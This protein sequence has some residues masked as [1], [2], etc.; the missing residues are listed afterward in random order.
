M[1]LCLRGSPLGLLKSILNSPCLLI[2]L[3]HTEHKT[4]R[5]NLGLTA[6]LYY[7]EGELVHWVDKGK[8][9][10]WLTVVQLPIKARWWGAPVV[11]WYF[12][13]T[14]KH[15]THVTDTLRQNP[16]N[17]ISYFLSFWGTTR[18]FFSAIFWH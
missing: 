8:K 1:R 16:T 18:N 4:I 6:R 12:S 2:L 3:I 11:L 17:S 10:V 9:K 5:W 15:C 7:L 14:N 13:Q